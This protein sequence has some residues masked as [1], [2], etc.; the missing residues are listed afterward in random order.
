MPTKRPSLRKRRTVKPELRVDVTRIEYQRLC[1]SVN[2]NAEAIKR[3]ELAD[4]IQF[5]RTAEIQQELEALKKGRR[6]N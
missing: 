2:R 4:Q 1:D 6:S 3:L 5:R